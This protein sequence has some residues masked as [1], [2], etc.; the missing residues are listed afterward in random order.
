MAINLAGKHNRSDAESQ[1]KSVVSPAKNL[2]SPPLFD[3][4]QGEA[5]K[6]VA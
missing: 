4:T 2:Y 1:P 6:A 3:Q 5:Q